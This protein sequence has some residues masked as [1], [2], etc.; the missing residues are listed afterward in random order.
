MIP[1]PGS[2]RGRKS[3]APEKIKNKTKG[4]NNA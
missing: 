1:K 2:Y 3:S 4:I